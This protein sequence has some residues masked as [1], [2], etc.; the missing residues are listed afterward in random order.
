[1]LGTDIASLRRLQGVLSRFPGRFVDKILSEAEKKQFELI[2][3][4]RRRLE[5]LGGRFS[6]KEALFKATDSALTWKRVSILPQKGGRPR[7]FIDGSLARG[8]EISIAHEEEFVVATVV[9]FE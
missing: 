4:E 5:F 7:I 1:M 8:I 9:K 6:G 3:G 2:G